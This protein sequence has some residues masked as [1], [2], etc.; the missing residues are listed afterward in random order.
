M[1]QSQLTTMESV[2]QET[3]VLCLDISQSVNQ[4]MLQVTRKLAQPE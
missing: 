4:L 3:D 2:E 1:L